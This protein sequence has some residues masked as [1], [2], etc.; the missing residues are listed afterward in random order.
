[1]PMLPLLRWANTQNQYSVGHRW[2]NERGTD[3][4]QL[5]WDYYIHD[6]VIYEFVLLWT[7]RMLSSS[8]SS[9]WAIF[10]HFVPFFVCVFCCVRAKRLNDFSC[11]KIYFGNIFYEPPI[12]YM[13]HEP[14]WK[15]SFFFIQF[16][17]SFETSKK[18][19]FRVSHF[20]VWFTCFFSVHIYYAIFL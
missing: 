2:P 9:F 19:W 18:I 7:F 20:C 1:M 8:S 4:Q 5:I 6:S 10:F 16:F 13:L 11:S 15:N 12:K 17:F 3:Q 14:K